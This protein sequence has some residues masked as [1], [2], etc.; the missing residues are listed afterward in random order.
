VIG[1]FHTISLFSTKL[2]KLFD[3]RRLRLNYFRFAGLSAFPFV[4]LFR[5]FFIVGMTRSPFR[6]GAG[7]SWLYKIQKGPGPF[8]PSPFLFDSF[9]P[10]SQPA[11]SV[12][13]GGR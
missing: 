7:A 9:A 3:P 6:G 11:L 10:S 4:P 1:V 8:G 13:P 5:P 12:R 2:E